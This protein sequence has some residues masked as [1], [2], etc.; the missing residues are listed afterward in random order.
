MS[1]VTDQTSGVVFGALLGGIPV[2]EV[3]D[4]AA[5][6][7]RLGFELLGFGD[8]P[9]LWSEAWITMAVAAT[10]TSRIRIAPMVTN[11]VSRHLGSV[12]GAA[13]TL[14][15]LSGGR[16]TVGLGIGDSGVLNLGLKPSTLRELEQGIGRLRALLQGQDVVLPDASVVKN[17]WADSTAPIIVAAAGRRTLAMAGRVADGILLSS[18]VRIDDLGKALEHV[19]EGRRERADQQAPFETWVQIRYAVGD[20]REQAV[21]EIRTVVAAVGHHAIGHDPV[22]KGV[23]EHLH[24]A[25][26][27]LVARYDPRYHCVPGDSPNALLIDELGL[28][29]Y[30]IER[31]AIAGSPEE[32]AQQAVALARAGYL[33]MLMAT[34]VRTAQ[35]MQRWGREVIPLVQQ[36]L[37]R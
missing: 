12:A 2:T 17:T 13:A 21:D 11:L 28:T 24:D 15:L 7:E 34:P 25:C 29:D 4:A 20:T 14:D 26:R 3:G 27:E 16:L 10:R 1:A 6:A 31:F 9:A 5:A 35:N 37:A 33:H 18:G 19:A 8:S 32:C 22:A 36:E 23:P 30:L